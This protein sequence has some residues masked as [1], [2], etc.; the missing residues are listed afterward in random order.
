M[1][2]NTNLKG[3]VRNTTLSK[4]NGL[5]PLF[6]A[7]VNSIH[8]IEEAQLIP[9]TGKISI[10]ILRST[11]LELGIDKASITGFKITDNGIGFNDD[12]MQSFMTLDSEYKRSKGCRGIGRLMWLKAFSKVNISSTYKGINGQLESVKFSFDEE[13]GVT[14]LERHPHTRTKLETTVHLQGFFTKYQQAT[15]KKADSIASSLVEHCLWYFICPGGAPEIKIIDADEEIVLSD[16]YAAYM[17]GSTS[18]TIQIGSYQFEL[19]HVRLQTHTSQTHVVSYCA[20]NRLV[21]EKSLNGQIPGLFGRIRDHDNDINFVYACY[22]SSSY[23]D[24]NVRAE[25]DGFD[26]DKDIEGF[27]SDISLRTIDDS[28]TKSIS[29]YLE[30]Y[31]TENKKLGRKRTEDFIS[32]NAPRYR[33]ILSRIS[34]DELC[35]DPDISDKEL[36]LKLHGYLSNI[37]QDLLKEG[38]DIM[39]PEYAQDIEDYTQKVQSYLDKAE[40][41][42]KSDLA[43]YVSRRKVVIDILEQAIRLQKDGRYAKEELIHQLI[44]PMRVSSNDVLSDSCNLWLIDERLAFH[45]YLASDKTLN[46]I[47][48]TDSTETKEPDLCALNVFDN[49]FLVSEENAPPLQGSI[50]VVEIKR[51]MRN[52]A[53]EGEDKDP[54]EQALGYLKKIRDGKVKTASG[55]LIPDSDSL[56]GFCYVICDITKTIKDR[57]EIHDAVRTSDG[58]GYFFYHKH[59]KAYVEIISFSRL[60]KSAKERNRAF[61]DKL[62]LPTN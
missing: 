27:L 20:A 24:D 38:H 9:G 47:P 7:V 21:Q 17:L 14:N 54:I 15:L 60:V 48:I 23:L 56:P 34:D 22:V 43:A 57:C 29:S 16:I 40:D 44:M 45:N 53:S 49:P 6:E 39:T 13:K 12:N 5:M 11:E 8:S 33:P 58:L 10:T 59:F 41:L 31:L 25:R 36:E 26:I 62:G 51:P 18:E 4:G 35:V 46:S 30:K 50:V 55:I 1:T 19:T 32:K 2:I 52:D 3:R 42:K 37:E 61:F 28:V